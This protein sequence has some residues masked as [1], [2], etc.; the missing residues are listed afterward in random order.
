MTTEHCNLRPPPARLVDHMAKALWH[1]PLTPYGRGHI[2]RARSISIS[3]GLPF[4]RGRNPDKRAFR[5]H[6][7]G[8]AATRIERVTSLAPFLLLEL[9]KYW[10]EHIPPPPAA[11]QK[12]I[13]CTTVTGFFPMEAQFDRGIFEGLDPI[14]AAI[15]IGEIIMDW[16]F[17]SMGKGRPLFRGNQIGG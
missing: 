14:G 3:D 9:L 15:F 13:W 17:L 1:W 10:S 8:A 12:Y 4:L 6:L 16:L 11:R 2:G 5:G 7:S